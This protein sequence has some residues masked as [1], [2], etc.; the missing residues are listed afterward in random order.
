MACHRINNSSYSDM[1]SLHIV[2]VLDT[3]GSVEGDFNVS[4]INFKVSSIFVV[5]T[6]IVFCSVIGDRISRDID[7]WIRDQS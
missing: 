7:A 5:Y 3:I 2:K 6:C 4:P 1:L